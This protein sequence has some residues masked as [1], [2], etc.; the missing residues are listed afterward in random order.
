MTGVYD[1][2]HFFLFFWGAA[3]RVLGVCAR[4]TPW[5]DRNEVGVSSGGSGMLVPGTM[6]PAPGGPGCCGSWVLTLLPQQPSHHRGPPVMVRAL[7]PAFWSAQAQAPQPATPYAVSL[8]EAA[9]CS[10]QGSLAPGSPFVAPVMP[11]AALVLT[12]VT[13]AGA[14]L[15]GPS[16][17]HLSTPEWEQ[18]GEH[19]REGAPSLSRVPVPGRPHDAPH[20]LWASATTNIQALANASAAT[21]DIPYASTGSFLAVRAV[22][23]LA[24]WTGGAKACRLRHSGG[25]P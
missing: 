19:G 10:P 9:P 3:V 15:A 6:N 1:H 11:R 16:E 17:A 14:A 21:T 4:P 20:G 25:S 22:G 8:A 24:P 12:E 5:N 2:T 23:T 7:W 13:R 18:R